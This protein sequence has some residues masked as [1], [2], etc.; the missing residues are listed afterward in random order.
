M[1]ELIVVPNEILHQKCKAIE[2]I[3]SS[4]RELAGELGEYLA[5]K[6]DD[7]IATGVSAPQFGES[8]RMLAFRLNPFS[9]V[10][11]TQVLINP[12]LIYGK[13]ER[14]MFE[15]CFSIPDKKFVLRRYKTVRVRGITLESSE[16]SF[17]VH[18]I[19]AQTIQHELNHLDGVLIDKLGKEVDG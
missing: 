1:K 9:E 11:S 17:K 12:V 15:S 14:S 18:D 3:T 10:P 19:V 6:H 8:V 13:K 5:Y 2:E 7:L 16:V 4:I